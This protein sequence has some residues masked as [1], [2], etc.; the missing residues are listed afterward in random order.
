ME[1]LLTSANLHF[2][3]S[4]WTFL[5]VKIVVAHAQPTLPGSNH[6][7]DVEGAGNGGWAGYIQVETVA[8]VPQ[9]YTYNVARLRQRCLDES[10]WG[11]LTA[12]EADLGRK[13]CSHPGLAKPRAF[14][15]TLTALHHA[16]PG[17]IR[18]EN[19]WARSIKEPMSLVSRKITAPPQVRSQL[20]DAQP[21]GNPNLSK[22]QM[23]GGGG[24]QKGGGGG[25][26]LAPGGL[27][28]SGLG[29]GGLGG[30]G[31]SG[32]SAGRGGLGGGAPGLGGGAPGLGGGAPGLGGGAPG[33]GGGA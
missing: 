17:N 20:R 19:I 11:R 23:P 6:D 26:K 5:S 4:A 29:G 18:N 28:G 15:L 22:R 30:T 31:G 27:G 13:S 7:E 2:S 25:G 24:K 12:W 16:L 33:L 8:T 10:N 1:N 3:S 14:L 9:S 32:L 21:I